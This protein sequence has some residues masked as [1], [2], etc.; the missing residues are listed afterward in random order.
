M[1]PHER[2]SEIDT[3]RRLKLPQGLD[4]S[5]LHQR[6]EITPNNG[7]TPMAYSIHLFRL[8]KLNSEIKYVAN[9]VARAP[10]PYAYPANLDMN[11]WQNDML[12]QL[13]DWKANMPTI[14]D[15]RSMQYMQLECKLRYHSI[16][17]LLLRP[18]PAIP[19]PSPEALRQCYHSSVRCLLLFDQMYREDLLAYSWM[20][21]H[22]LVI[23]VLTM[24]YCI[25]AAPDIARSVDADSV[26]EHLSIG[27]SILSATGEHWTGARKCRDILRDLGRSTVRQ[28]SD[29]RT[30]PSERRGRGSAAAYADGRVGNSSEDDE[31]AVMGD[32]RATE[33]D[34]FDPTLD[35]L[36]ANTA[37]DDFFGAS[38][39][40]NIDNIVQS[41]FQDLIP[42]Y[43]PGET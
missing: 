7:C 5:S 26:M 8:A 33:Q 38:E 21:F 24:L 6:H 35:D 15:T 31:T 32:V 11:G 2:H 41:L 17:L 22:G 34:A 27:L 14:T 1:C 36:F 19:R 20:T 16:R 39:S 43:M 40:V 18:S 23:G 29:A 42:A 10:P 4:D 12:R 25:K 3:D 28:L 13:K 9:S 30:R 37:M